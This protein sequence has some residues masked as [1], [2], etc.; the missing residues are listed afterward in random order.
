MSLECEYCFLPFCWLPSHAQN[1][2]APID[3]AIASLAHR[4]AEPLQKANVTKVFVADLRGPQGQEHPVGKWLAEQLS[5]SLERDFLGLQVLD[6]SQEVGIAEDNDDPGNQFQ[7]S[8]LKRERDLARKL[9]ANVVVG[10]NFAKI[11]QGIG[12]SLYAKFTSDSP[13]LLGETNGLIPISDEIA[14]VS[15]DPIP[16]QKSGIARAGIGGTTIPSCIHCRPPN[17]TEEARAAKYQGVV[18][19]QVTVTAEGRATN[20]AIV[21]APG[22]GLEAKAL[23]A[24]RDWKFKPAV[25]PD[26]N[27]VSVIVPIEVTFRLY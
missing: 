9:G 21:K 11:Q 17:Y 27:P 22:K 5:K 25:G 8:V 1:A 3:P 26:G 14:S 19:L 24:V 6:R 20:I 10:G 7:P 4:I 2:P 18:V 16:L 12:I 15:T 23:E 13:R